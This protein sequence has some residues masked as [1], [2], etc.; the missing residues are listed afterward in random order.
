VLE[1]KIVTREE[2]INV[3]TEAAELEHGLLCQY[4]FAA[5]SRKSSKIQTL[6]RQGL[7]Y[8]IRPIEFSAGGWDADALCGYMRSR[9]QVPYRPL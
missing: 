2:L 4:L 7:S 5:P 6:I 3:L 8:P 1:R 9:L